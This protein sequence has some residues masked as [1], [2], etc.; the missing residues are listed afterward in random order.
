MYSEQIQDI[1]SEQQNVLSELTARA[2][3]FVGARRP[4]R[5]RTGRW[6]EVRLTGGIYPSQF[7]LA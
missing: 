7:L 4:N 2:E 5:R 3:T 1:L 6:F